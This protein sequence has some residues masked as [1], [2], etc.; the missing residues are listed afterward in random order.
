MKFDDFRQEFH[1]NVVIF[2]LSYVITLNE[3]A[4]KMILKIPD[5]KGV[6]R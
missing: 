6:S 5:Y 2:F 1:Y 3:V 4:E